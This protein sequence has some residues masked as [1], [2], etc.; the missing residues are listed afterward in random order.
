MTNLEELINKLCPN[1]IEYKEIREIAWTGIGLATSVTKHKRNQGVTLLHNSDIK[2]NK[3][4]LKNVEFLDEEFVKK[5][6]NKI[7]RLHDIITVHTGDIGTSAVIEEDYVGSI[8]FTTII[9][10]I[11]DFN[12]VNP[13]YLSHYLNS[14]VFKSMVNKISI[15]DRNNLN[16][17]DYETISVPVPPLKVQNEIVHI[18]DDFTLKTENLNQDL[19][20]ELTL[21]Q[22]QYS[23]YKDVLFSF[24]NKI[25]KKTFEELCHLSA[26]GDINKDNVKK[27][28]TEEYNIPV[29]SNGVGNNAIYGYTNVSKIKAPCITISGRGT[30]GYSELRTEDFYPIVRLICAK[31]KTDIIDIEYLNHFIK[32][33]EFKIPT[34]GI[35]QLTV[36]M[37]KNYKI[38]IPP[39]EEQK[40]IARIL[41]EYD[42][43]IN[44]ISMELSA[45]IEK[46]QQQ[47]EYY[48]DVLLS[49]KE[50]EVNE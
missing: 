2:Q 30:I 20:S 13:Y 1:G 6:E 38:P 15:S 7:H 16:Q 32:T 40:R 48:R 11:K 25:E 42:I 47:Y 24:D 17:K 35:P 34:T 21:R 43:V 29:L 18:L 3:I 23:Y 46:R 26:G 14:R 45:E 31:P 41:N 28:K 5:N 39:I 36:P 33:I 8:G 49:F 10:R 9:T 4:V 44:N 12:E 22:K 50:V 27:E 37:L 19:K